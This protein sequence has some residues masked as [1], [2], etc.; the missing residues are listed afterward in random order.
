MKDCKRGLLLSHLEHG[1]DLVQDRLRRGE[2][3][4]TLAIRAVLLLRMRIR[5]LGVCQ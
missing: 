3:L 4:G 1:L 5:V 2:F